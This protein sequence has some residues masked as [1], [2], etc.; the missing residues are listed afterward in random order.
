[1]KIKIP[2][3]FND[4]ELSDGQKILA[5]LLCLA[6]NYENKDTEFYI[7]VSDI[8]VMMGARSIRS[9]K[10]P[11]LMPFI[12]HF[13]I[14]MYTNDV[15]SF[16]L[17]DPPAQTHYGLLQWEWVELEQPYAI[18]LWHY[19][20]GAVHPWEKGCTMHKGVCELADQPR[21]FSHYLYECFEF[22]TEAYEREALGR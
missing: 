12:P 22:T 17:Q 19:I 20:V 15:W 18:N 10:S 2:K 4:Y 5:G 11:E 13:K 16:R 3:F 1:M 14:G 7:N 8:R 6:Y 9:L 21:P